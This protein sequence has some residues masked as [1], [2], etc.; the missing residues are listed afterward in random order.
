RQQL[1]RAVTDAIDDTW[2]AR[3]EIRDAHA[4]LIGLLDQLVSRA[5]REGT[6]RP[7]IGAMDVMML[8]KGLCSAATAFAHV[9]ST[10]IDRQM[11]LARAGITADPAATPLRGRTRTLE[12]LDAAEVS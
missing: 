11:A 4:E 1:D 3:E 5:Q 9:D 2:L 8:L 10:L 12:Q 6:V 7:D